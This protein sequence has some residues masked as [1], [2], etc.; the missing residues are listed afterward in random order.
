MN[1]YIRYLFNRR[2]CNLYFVI[3]M[4]LDPNLVFGQI[5]NFEVNPNLNREPVKI[6]FFQ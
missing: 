6:A 1:F 3:L 5:K 4:I 2:A